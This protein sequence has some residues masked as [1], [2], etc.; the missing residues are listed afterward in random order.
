LV[1]I[2]ETDG[3]EEEEGPSYLMLEMT[4]TVSFKEIDIDKML[5]HTTLDDFLKGLYMNSSKSGPLL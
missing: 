3:E 2:E 1:N 4:S 5:E